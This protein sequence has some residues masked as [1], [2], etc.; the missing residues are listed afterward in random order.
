MGNTEPFSSPG[1]GLGSGTLC[2]CVR[3]RRPDSSPP[4]PP[5]MTACSTL[6]HEAS[7]CTTLIFVFS[8]YFGKRILRSAIRNVT[9]TLGGVVCKACN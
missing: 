9:C 1:T 8:V 6:C 2:C 3:G 5:S 7:S 4:L